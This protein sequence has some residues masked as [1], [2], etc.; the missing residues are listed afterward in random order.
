MREIATIY[1]I[2]FNYFAQR[3]VKRFM[4]TSLE[5][6]YLHPWWKVRT[7]SFWKIV[8]QSTILFPMDI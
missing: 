5:Q 2:H 3:I 4:E 6:S 7:K 1:H 8:N